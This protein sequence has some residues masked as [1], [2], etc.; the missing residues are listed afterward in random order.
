MNLRRSRVRHPTA[1]LAASA[2][3]LCALPVQEA[4]ADDLATSVIAGS[5]GLSPGDTTV[6]TV[7]ESIVRLFEERPDVAW[8]G[9]SLAEQPF[10]VYVPDCMCLFFNPPAGH[11]G[12][13]EPPREWPSLNGAYVF[14]DGS[15]PGLVGQLAFD[16]DVADTLVVAVGLPEQFPAGIEDIEF[17]I[18]AYIVHE[19]F[20][21]YQHTAFERTSWYREERYPISD[22]ENSALAW[23]EMRILED[24]LLASSSGDEETCRHRA[25]QF[26][27]VRHLRWNIASEFVRGFERGKELMEGTAKHVE[28][29]AVVGAASLEYVSEIDGTMSPL[30][31][32][33]P[34]S[35]LCELIV[36][37][38]VER[39]GERCLQPQDVPRN[40]IYAVGSAQCY[41]LDHLG[42]EWREAAA[43]GGDD[44]SYSELLQKNLEMP[45]PALEPAARAA[46]GEYGYDGLLAAAKTAWEEYRRGYS[47]ALAR[48]ESQEGTRVEIVMPTTNV[49]RSRRTRE[50]KWLMNAGASCL[51]A[52]FEVYTARGG[53]WSFELHDAGLLE[54]SDW[55]AGS[56][57]V[58]IYE[59]GDLKVSVDGETFQTPPPHEAD[60]DSLSV[61]GTCFNLTSDDSGR[62]SIADEVVRVWLSD[63]LSDTGRETGR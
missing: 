29:R 44:F 5:R 61:A 28:L 48:F 11:S 47:D 34:R 38:L 45:D 25:G 18:F 37:E 56:R 30:A 46:M 7:C 62:V 55:D 16:V 21:Q 57:K 24:A 1:A 15:L 50:R 54:L 12:F 31:G 9:Y 26:V 19:A 58:V 52:G 14:R 53:G 17:E 41:L 6:F 10:L 4:F 8:P 43:T 51:C 27:A 3:L 23:L 2:I 40:R 35:S 33:L 39:R 63:G 42:C 49:S 20:H 22:A 13:E 32:V 60:Y 36:D 59:P